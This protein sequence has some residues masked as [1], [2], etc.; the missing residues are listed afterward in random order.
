[1]SLSEVVQEQVKRVPA[2]R[3]IDYATTF[4]KTT[5]DCMEDAI[6]AMIIVATELDRS[7]QGLPWNAP[8]AEIFNRYMDMGLTDLELALSA[9]APDE[10]PAVEGATF[11]AGGEGGE[12]HGGVVA[13]GG[14][15]GL[16]AEPGA[17]V[18]GGGDSAV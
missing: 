18:P 16:R 2:R 13:D 3:W 11:P 6:I 14:R 1:M 9:F 7:A 10:E 5:Q 17:D 15:E 12:E 4:G 8:A